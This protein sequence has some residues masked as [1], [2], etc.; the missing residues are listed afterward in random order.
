MEKISVIIPTYNGSRNIK[1]AIQSVFNQDYPNIEIIVV[2][3]ASTDDTVDL[4]ESIK[5]SRIKLLKHL[6]NR[7]VSAARNTGIKASTGKYIAFLD[8][9][10]EW[11]PTKLSKQVEYLEKKDNKK[12]KAVICSHYM[13]SGK[14]RRAVTFK[15]EGNVLKE[16]LMME[17]SLAAGSSLMFDRDIVSKVGYLDEK[18]SINEDVGFVIRYLRFFNLGMMKESLSIVNG[19][20][21]R[22]SGEKLLNTKKM[23]L[24]DFKHDI[25]N[26]GR[27]ISKKIYARQWLQVSKH[28]ALDGDMKNTIKYYFK[29]LSFSCLL[30]QYTKFLPHENYLTIPYYLLKSIIFGKQKAKR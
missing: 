21:G 25:E 2:N 29:S 6:E 18:Y 22:A 27:S 23:L 1:R 3:D 9:D 5:D 30:S 15:K 17:I 20:S 28:F 13:F 24:N 11:L 7:G 16:I 19:H 14:N 4:V 26:L 10:D 12:W 8:D